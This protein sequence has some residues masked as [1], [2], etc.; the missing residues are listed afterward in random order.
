M[1]SDTLGS[2]VF[3]EFVYWELIL[4]EISYGALVVIDLIMLGLLL[5]YILSRRAQLRYNPGLQLAAALF[6]FVFGN[7]VR[8]FGLWI[9]YMNFPPFEEWRQFG[10]IVIILSPII[11]LL[12]GLATV[13]TLTAANHR[14]RLMLWSTVVSILFPVLTYL[15]L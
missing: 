9:Q 3:L 10:T 4:R 5:D 6:V 8:S 13:T 1:M 15:L 12:G 14:W 11:V 2:P 7:L